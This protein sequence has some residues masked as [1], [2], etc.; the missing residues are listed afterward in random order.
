MTGF[1]IELPC[2]PSTNSLYGNSTTGRDKT[3]RYREWLLDASSRMLA[4]V[5][6]KQPMVAE[7]QIVITLNIQKGAD[8]SN[9]I[10]ALEDLL[11][12]SGVLVNDSIVDRITISRDREMK[13]N[14]CS[15]H[16]FG[17]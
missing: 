2:P 14:T 12:R 8:I 9:R 15:M 7:A 5:R 13:L 4:S 3:K 10:K 16:V 1:Q 11:V 17:K 6:P